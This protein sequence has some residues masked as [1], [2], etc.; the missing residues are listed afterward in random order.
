MGFFVLLFDNF[1]N[2]NQA[3]FF[4][5][6]NFLNAGSLTTRKYSNQNLKNMEEYSMAYGWEDL[7]YNKDVNSP[8]FKL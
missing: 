1:N 3:N 5:S 7:R 2:I 8:K 6:D 4:I